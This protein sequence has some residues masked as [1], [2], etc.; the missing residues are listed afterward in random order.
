MD[1]I[2][3]AEN[4]MPCLY[5]RPCG[6]INEEAA[7]ACAVVFRWAEGALSAVHRGK[8]NVEAAA[9]NNG[10]KVALFPWS[11]CFDV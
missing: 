8:V 3:G 5:A 4:F 7:G 11:Y 6:G 2:G 10:S 9:S 1:L